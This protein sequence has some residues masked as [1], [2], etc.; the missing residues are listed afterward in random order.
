[1]KLDRGSFPFVGIDET[2]KNGVI[3]SIWINLPIVFFFLF[4]CASTQ[5]KQDESRDAKFYNNR[6][7]AFGEKGQY[8]QAISD[9]NQA[10]EMNPRYNKAYNNRGIVYRLK[11]QYNQAISDFNKAISINP[12]EAEAYNNLAW[13]FATAGA[14]GFR[15]G[16][17]AVELALR[18]CGLSDWRNA[19]Y[20]D[21]LAAAYARVGDFD[22][23]VKWE[24]KALESSKS[25][26]TSEFQQRLNFY[27]ERKPWPAD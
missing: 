26:E 25:A 14:Q 21:T 16:K 10:I 13:L 9:F 12:L 24:K 8:D 19:E 1:M 22:N 18:A 4:S 20:L 23:A 17:K 7:I 11:G 27:R 3:K 5:Q 15:N 2:L 6:G